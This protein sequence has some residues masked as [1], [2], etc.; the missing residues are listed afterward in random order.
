MKTFKNITQTVAILV[1]SFVS[2]SAVASHKI[3][4]ST[5]KYHGSIIP[6]VTLKQIDIQGTKKAK[7]QLCVMTS[8]NGIMIPS[9]QLTE[10]TISSNNSYENQLVSVVAPIIK[11]KLLPTIKVNG[12]YIASV[13][14]N[15]VTVISNSSSSSERGLNTEEVS[16]Q[17]DDHFA[18]VTVKQSFNRLMNYFVEKIK[19]TAD[20][21]LNSLFSK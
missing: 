1:L 19:T 9:V 8:V 6:S 11:S 13:D 7:G 20:K 12:E 4:T 14:L 16:E 15:E 18:N 3:K 17:I 5:T 10:V 2:L 21:I